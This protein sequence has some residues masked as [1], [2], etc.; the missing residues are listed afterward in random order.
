MHHFIFP[1][2]DTYITNRVPYVERNFGLDVMLIIGTNDQATRQVNST[3]DFL[4]NN[5]FVTNFHVDNFTGTILS[6]SLAGTS[7]FVS[8]TLAYSGSTAFTASFFSGTLTGSYMGWLTGSSISSSAHTGSL[9][10]FSGSIVASNIIGVVTGSLKAVS[11]GFLIF[12]GIVSGSTGAIISGSILGIDTK[13]IQNVTTVTTKFINRALVKF[14]ISAISSSVASGDIPN[15]SFKLKL[16]VAR[17]QNL[18]IPYTIYALPI[19]QSWEMGRG[20]FFDGGDID[21]TSWTY[22]NYKSGSRWY[23]ITSSRTNI[24]D[25][26]THPEQ[27]TESFARGGGTWYSQYISSQSFNY[28]T[29]DISMDVSSIVNGWISGSIPNEG[30]ILLSSDEFQSTGS[31]MQLFFFSKDTNTIYIPRLDV[32]WSDSSYITGSTFTSSINK[33]TSSGSILSY[34]NGGTVLFASVSA[35]LSGSFTGSAYVNGTNLTGSIVATATNSVLSGSQIVGNITGSIVT[36]SIEGTFLNGKLAGRYFTG[37]SDGTSS[38]NVVS[39][40]SYLLS[41]SRVSGS[42]NIYNQVVSDVSG[43]LFD[44]RLLGIYNNGQFTGIL[45]SGLLSGYFVTGSLTGSYSTSSAVTESIIGSSSLDA[46]QFNQPFTIVVQNLQP[47]VKAGNIIRVDL[48]ARKEFTLKN[49]V[50]GT[51]FN[52]F[53]TASYLP[54]SSYYSI[55][56]NETEKIVIDFDNYTKVSCDLN[57]NYFLL[58]TSGLPQER[59]FRILIKT[60]ESGSIYTIDTGNTFKVVR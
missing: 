30:I 27:A 31:E 22:K 12:N 1:S 42:S 43:S 48:F 18:P 46:L 35:S 25:F 8:G 16:D 15:P 5:V 21:G 13:N 36:Q 39:T 47:E 50:R 26:I 28:Q 55:K 14:D 20:Y 45:E 33:Y 60:E 24:I 10:N 52:Q 44:G 41:G 4:Y 11:N 34:F 32:G 29:S 3:K 58:D 6:G 40:G 23:P 53:I 54:T 57:G 59:Y 19:S 49:F 51:Q 7:S 37:S 56:D 17:E 38:F 9:N 2:K